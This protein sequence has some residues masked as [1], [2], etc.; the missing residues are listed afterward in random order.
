MKRENI[1]DVRVIRGNTESQLSI[2]HL[3]ETN[4]Y[5]VS[6]G[7]DVERDMSIDLTF[8]ALAEALLAVQTHNAGDGDVP[9]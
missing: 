6:V 2:D 7:S 9:E 4:R 1:Y 8:D 5:R 3:P